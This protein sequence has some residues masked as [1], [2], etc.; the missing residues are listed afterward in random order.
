MCYPGGRSHQGDATNGS[1][2]AGEHDGAGEDAPHGTG[3][4]GATRFIW[5][6]SAAGKPHVLLEQ[7]CKRM[8]ALVLAGRY[9]RAGCW[10]VRVYTLRVYL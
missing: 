9:P 8:R 3:G 5:Y 7:K 6:F 1:H 4:K 10:E 2:T